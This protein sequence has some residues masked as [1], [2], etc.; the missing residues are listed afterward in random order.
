MSHVDVHSAI[1]NTPQAVAALAAAAQALGGTLEQADKIRWFGRHV[2]DW[3]IPEG[4]T[5]SDIGKCKYKISF[6]GVSYD[7]GVIPHPQDPSKL[8]IYYDF[9]GPGRQLQRIVGKG[10]EKLMQQYGLHA[11]LAWAKS[12]GKQASVM[13]LPNGY[14][15]VEAQ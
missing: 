12:K 5:V 3:P 4:F 9:Y 13:Q 10:A 7:V 8:C 14:Y 11:A 15:Q 2:G 1:A 6:P